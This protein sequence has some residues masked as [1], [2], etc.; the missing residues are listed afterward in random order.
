MRRARRLGRL[1]L[2]RVVEVLPHA[3]TTGS[4]HRTAGRPPCRPGALD[5]DDAAARM[6]FA[7]LDDLHAQ[8][9]SRRGEWNEDDTAV[10]E[11]AD[12]ITSRGEAVDLDPIHCGCYALAAASA[13]VSCTRTRAMRL[14]DTSTTIR[15]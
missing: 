12:T 13:G 9:V 14:P 3:A 5:L 4:E 8:H 1:E 11:S 2:R 10:L 15:S 7:A 6:A